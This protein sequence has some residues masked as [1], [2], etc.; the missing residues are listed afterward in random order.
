MRIIPY[1]V[2]LLLIAFYRTNLF[3]LFSIGNIFIYL[4][5]LIVILVA[6]HKDFV[7]TLWFAAAAGLVYDAPDPAHLGIQMSI[8]VILSVG[9]SQ[10]K[11]SLNLDSIKSRLL[12]VLGALFVY[13]FPH[14]LVYATSGH[15]NFF[16]LLVTV[17]L[18]SVVYTAVLAWLFFL[19]RSGHLSYTRLKSIF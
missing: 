15:E 5:A 17:G 4:T 3:E 2:Y 7:T 11:E 14:T 8:L 13:S 19:I 6:L 12:L 9:T 10:A 18:P 16:L 1:I